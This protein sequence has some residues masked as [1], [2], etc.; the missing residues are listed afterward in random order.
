VR[1]L[2]PNVTVVAKQ[3]YYPTATANQ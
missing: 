1:V 3:G 2:L